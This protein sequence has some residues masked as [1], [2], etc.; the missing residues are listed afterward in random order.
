[1]FQERLRR[2]V[3]GF[4]NRFVRDAPV[5]LLDNGFPV[6]PASDLLEDIGDEYP[7]TAKRRLAMTY[8]WIGNDESPEDFRGLCCFHALY[9]CMQSSLSAAVAERSRSAAAS[10]GWLH[11]AVRWPYVEGICDEQQYGTSKQPSHADERELLAN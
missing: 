3:H 6:E 4:S 8:F 1:M 7:C 11:R 9:P 10:S 5:P 2:Q